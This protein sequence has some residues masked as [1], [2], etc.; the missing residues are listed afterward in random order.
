MD[1]D[2]VHGVLCKMDVD[3]VHGMLCKMDVDRVHGMLC[4]M[5]VDGICRRLTSVWSVMGRTVTLSTCGCR[6][7][8]SVGTSHSAGEYCPLLLW[9]HCTVLV[10]TSL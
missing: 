3:R 9:A 1:V 4:E 6:S 7:L 8:T 5:D 2:R 10:S